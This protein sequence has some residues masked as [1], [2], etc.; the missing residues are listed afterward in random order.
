[1][2]P[3]SGSANHDLTW[4]VIRV[5]ARTWEIVRELSQFHFTGTSK[6]S[7]VNVFLPLLSFASVPLFC[8]ITPFNGSIN[9]GAAQPVSLPV[10]SETYF[11]CC[12]LSILAEFFPAGGALQHISTQFCVTPTLY[13][14]ALF[15]CPSEIG[16]A[17]WRSMGFE[18]SQCC[19][20]PCPR[21][22]P[23]TRS[24]FLHFQPSPYANT[25]YAISA[26][27]PFLQHTASLWVNAS[28]SPNTVLCALDN[29]RQHPLHPQSMTLSPLLH[30]Q[31]S[32]YAN[33]PYTISALTPFLKCT[34]LQCMTVS[35]PWPATRCALGLISSY[36]AALSSSPRPTTYLPDAGKYSSA[37]ASTSSPFPHFS[38]TTFT[39]CLA[40]VCPAYTGSSAHN[41][42]AIKQ[43]A[44]GQ[45]NNLHSIAAEICAEVCT[46]VWAGVWAEA[47]AEIW[48]DVL[49]EALARGCT[50]VPDKFSTT[51]WVR[52]FVGTSLDT[53]PDVCV[54]CSVT[55][56]ADHF[57]NGTRHATCSAPVPA[58][59]SPCSW[60]GA[61][62]FLGFSCGYTA[63]ATRCCVSTCNCVIASFAAPSCR[64][65]LVAYSVLAACAACAA[66]AAL[67]SNSHRTP[68]WPLPHY[69]PA[70]LLS[71][72]TTIL[73]TSH[74]CQPPSP[75]GRTFTT[76]AD[77]VFAVC[78]ACS[79][80]V[81]LYGSSCYQL[82]LPQHRPRIT[83]SFNYPRLI[84][85]LMLFACNCP[86]ATPA[87]PAGGSIRAAWQLA[88]CAACA[89]LCSTRRSIFAC[90]R[91][92]HR[93]R[94]T[95]STRPHRYL[96]FLLLFACGCPRTAAA[97]PP[98]CCSLQAALQPV[99]SAFG[100]SAVVACLAASAS[101]GDSL[102][103][104]SQEGESERAAQAA[105]SEQ[106]K[107]SP[108]PP[109][110][111]LAAPTPGCAPPV[112]PSA[113]PQ[114]TP[115][116]PT[117]CTPRCKPRT[118]DTDQKRTVHSRQTPRSRAYALRRERQTLAASAAAP[119]L[120]RAMF[121]ACH[122]CHK[123][124]RRVLHRRTVLARCSFLLRPSC[125]RFVSL[126]RARRR[127]EA[128]RLL[129]HP[130][131]PILHDVGY[132]PATGQ[133]VFRNA[134][135]VVSAIHPA[136]TSPDASVPA[137][138]ADGTVAPPLSPPANSSVVLCPEASGAWCYY[139]TALGTSSWF[140]PSDSTPLV[141]RH[142]CAVQLP[143]ELPPLLPRDLQLNALR[144]TNWTP[145][146][147]DATNEVL[148]MHT[149][150]GAV[151]HAPWI[152]LRTSSGLPY[153]ANL[154][155][156]E[157]RWLPPHRWMESWVCR[158]WYGDITSSTDKDQYPCPGWQDS[159]A[160]DDRLP[161]VGLMSRQ[162]VEGGAPYLHE[163]GKPSYPPD[164]FDTPL[165][166]PLDG[167]VQVTKWRFP[168]LGVPSPSPQNIPR[169]PWVL[170]KSVP[171]LA[172]T[173]VAPNLLGYL[174]SRCA[175][176]R[177]LLVPPCNASSVAADAV[178]L[179][180]ITPAVIAVSPVRRWCRN[181]RHLSS[182]T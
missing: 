169:C 36:R 3:R 23:I 70:L 19:F 18:S 123:L 57:R 149:R 55:R 124:R 75:Q 115:T 177:A 171:A 174:D 79:A 6:S 147:R 93:H 13:A 21:S 173:T 16:D 44:T 25:P 5:L 95:T 88:T 80:C 135:G 8:A 126:L 131:R 54:K 158:K 92:R 114:H 176:D 81:A 56:F 164:E 165:T 100:L 26:F 62:K 90:Q 162:C 27:T 178:S 17:V 180:A 51:Y 60:S 104:L 146:F 150:T 134:H 38:F 48:A 161:L 41:W 9:S 148:L 154:V 98:S 128:L 153:F 82:W 69:N 86:G 91:L 64:F 108:I 94:G 127:L 42:L 46:E 182:R 11:T 172:E 77:A 132:D 72:A 175:P 99:I 31:P 136:T 112:V 71:F 39:Q 118:R 67:R 78:A 15:W 32:P 74:T 107:H 125:G 152:V 29:L 144:F 129:Q 145:F 22:Q 179:A 2:A 10:G 143:P 138:A 167:Y 52:T 117:P 101:L 133:F 30:F 47:W 121:S 50:D 33:T 84:L 111:G 105:Q 53:W 97:T 160:Y 119:R 43:Q 102:G 137:F 28:F 142:L 106:A 116:A 87:N 110:L 65:V 1:M 14:N 140:P 155:T 83:V 49:A 35:F 37:P 20:Q 139:D 157:T 45:P 58:G 34:T 151:R 166:Y 24:S 156:H 73:A 130:P 141:S 59:I 170:S 89:A 68:V 168:P 109:G 63:T 76:V 120:W 12:H 159:R 113:A 66:R 85:G 61:G 163:R 122:F 96:F 103:S 181:G 4:C 40:K 7:M